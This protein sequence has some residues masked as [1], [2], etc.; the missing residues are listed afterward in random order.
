MV[1]L[2]LLAVVL[3][4]CDLATVSEPSNPYDPAFGGLR[5]ATAP[6]DLR[7][8]A[9]AL[10]SVTLAWTDQSSFETGVRVER[11]YGSFRETPYTPA[12][13]TIA[14]LPPD[15]TTYTDAAVTPGGGVQYRVTAIVAGGRDSEPS[16]RLTVRFQAER[17]PL[18]VSSVHA[19]G[20]ALDGQTLYAQRDG[21]ASTTAID[22]RT[23][24]VLA[25]IPGVYDTA[26]TTADGR[27][28]LFGFDGD[29]LHVA[30][31]RRG[32]T[33]QRAEFDLG[34]TSSLVPA[35]TVS[36][37]GTRVARLGY[38]PAAVQVWTLAGPAAPET[39][40]LDAFAPLLAG[41]SADGR[42][43]L[44]GSQTD[45]RAVDLATRRVLWAAP[46]AA[47]GAIVSPDGSRVLAVRP[48]LGLVLLDA[49]TGAVQAAADDARLPALFSADSRHVAFA[50]DR[51]NGPQ[52][53]RIV[54]TRGFE[55][56]LTVFNGDIVGFPARPTASGFV[57]YLGGAVVQ[58]GVNGTWAAEPTL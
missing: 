21:T 37:D 46:V 45:L 28:V 27:T 56:V 31:V 8:E 26:G 34:S 11:A 44:V 53:T 12:F 40:P 1:R 47:E 19:L 6:T 30:V 10:Q 48:G 16:Q 50:L 7:L 5:T 52:A 41:L 3:A 18:N 4:G 33:V 49:A 17:V 2:A 43:A 29:R 39:F 55:P 22:T 23:G 25:T 51:P 13:E 38:V 9:S 35:L 15:A 32:D 24:S 14:V 57:T 42:V 36:A 58:V 20:F 54:E